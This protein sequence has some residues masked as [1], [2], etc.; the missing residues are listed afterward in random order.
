MYVH[1]FIFLFD[2]FAII[3]LFL[4]WMKNDK[5]WILKWSYVREAYGEVGFSWSQIQVLLFAWTSLFGVCCNNFQNFQFQT[6]YS[7]LKSYI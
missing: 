4:S 6:L 2:E 1:T 7:P 5:H 3:I